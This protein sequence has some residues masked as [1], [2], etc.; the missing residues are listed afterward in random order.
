MY[1][2]FTNK[3][4]VPPGYA[5]KFL[6]I[7]RLTTVILFITFMQVSA[8][9]FAQQV[10]LNEHNASLESVLKKIRQQTGYDMIF[11]RQLVLKANP[12]TVNVQDVSVEVALAKVVDGQVLDFTVADKTITIKQKERTLLDKIKAVL[13]PAIDVRG[14]VVD[15]QNN[16]MPGVTIKTKDESRLVITDKNGNFFLSSVDEKAIMVISSVG[17][18]TREIAANADLKLVRMELSNSRLDEIQ[19]IAYGQTSQRLNTGDVSTVSAKEIA[20]QPVDNPLLALEGRVPGLFISQ[21]NGLPGGAVNVQIRGQNSIQSGNDPL[22]VID[23]VPYVSQLLPGQGYILGSSNY[24][25]PGNPLSY[26]NPADIET[27]SVLKDAGAT[28]IYGSRGANGVILI[29]TKKGK[30]GQTKVDVNVQNGYGEVTRKLQLLNTPEYLEMRNEAL[31]N[32]NIAPSLANGDYDLLQ[33][34]TTRYTDWQKVLLGNTAHYTDAQATISGGSETTQFLI[35]AG[36]HR[37]TVVFPGDFADQKG[38]MHFSLNNTSTN[39]KFNVLLTGSYVYGNNQLPDID[40]TSVALSL[41]PDAPPL[42][43]PDGSINWAPNSAGTSTILNPLARELNTYQNKTNNLV[44]NMVVSYTIIPGL[45]IKSSFGYTNMQ[46]TEFALF[47]LSSV[48][49]EY[50]AIS[51]NGATYVNNNINS[52]IIEPQ[53]SYEKAIGKG[54][55]NLLIGS[56]IEQ[57]NSN[58][59]QVNGGGYTS[60]QLL[61]DIESAATLVAAGSV[62]SVYK[63]N[64]LFGRVDYNW[65]DEYLIDLTERRDGSSRFGPANE[66]HDF[67]AA[68][69]GWIFTKIPALEKQLPFL[70]YGKLRMSYG[71]TGNDQIGDYQYLSLYSAVYAGGGSYQGTEG[72]APNRLSNPDLQWE[73]TRKF[74]AGLEMGFLKDRI[75]FT[76]S[77]SRNRSSNQLLGYSL[78]EITGFEQVTENFPATVQNTSL[79]FTLNTTNIKS[80]EFM[81]K[82]NINLT[83]PRNKLIAF[84][85]LATSSYS[86]YL[87][88]GQPVTVQKVFHYEGVDPATGQYKFA[89]TTNPFNPDY[90]QDQTV[91]ESTLPSFYGGFQNSIS[92]GDVTLDFLFQFVKQIG[93][94]SLYSGNIPGTFDA[95]QPVAVLNRWQK[96][97]DIAEFQ[98]FNSDYSIATGYYDKGSSDAAFSDASYIR[99]KN[100]SLS[101]NL[102]KSWITAIHVQNIRLFLQAQNLLTFTKYQGLDPE[103]L[104]NNSLP[105]LRV[106][107]TGL[108]VGL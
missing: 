71:T 41:A 29:T 106:I 28:S 35:G 11:D 1:K 60:D 17:Y 33:W 54:K 57:N 74:E 25:A 75:L 103:T 87:I 4:G 98:R 22:Y 47:P 43:N 21:A 40:L 56:T 10:T 27:I 64:A 19:V 102:K 18:I 23:G 83:V 99:L 88:I 91:L 90:A 15:E 6:L 62:A 26:L 85:N 44:A 59:Q 101:W 48:A 39:K 100:V 72:L 46:T 107:T 68:A 38:S 108:Q 14:Q 42:I 77:Y 32:D 66:F 53:A 45:N 63:Y 20:Q 31:K 82:S 8:A 78:P 96:P 34:D 79:E 105:P 7:M 61:G 76:A 73:L 92:Y 13:T 94:N 49:P 50:R 95:N 80:S 97:G 5:R 9:G 3:M 104:T 70:S 24:E 69:L 30:A 2:I 84:P 93:S 67:E 55:L 81:W 65:D 58:G 16:P 37:Q 51:Q 86:D 36:Y 12:I 89:S 52:W